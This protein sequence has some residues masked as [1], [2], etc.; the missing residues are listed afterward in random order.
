MKQFLFPAALLAFL[1]GGC[2]APAKTQRAKEGITFASNPIVAHR[3]AFKKNRLPE[4][5]IASLKHAIALNC[6]GSEFDVQMTADDSLVIN[7]DPHYNKLP[8]E[9]TPYAELIK[10]PLSNG[11]Q[12]PTLRTYLLE[13]MKNNRSTRLVLEIK[14][15]VISKER[16]QLIAQ[17]AVAL[18]HELGA[19]RMTVYISFDYDIC[20]KVKELDPKTHVQYLNGDKSPEVV[21]AGGLDGV[22]YHYSVFQKHPE[23]I[24]QAKQQH[25]A[26]N[27]WTVNTAAEMDWLLANGFEFITTNEPELLTERIKKT[28]AAKG[29]KLV[30]SDEFNNNG[31]PDDHKW[32]YDV[33]GSGWG[34]RELQYY[35]KADSNNALVKD[36]TLRIIAHKEKREQN[37]Y[38]SAR[39]ITKGKGDWLYG[40]VEVSAKLPAG[41]GVWP[42]IWM[43]PTDWKY[44]GWPASGEMDIMENVGYN[45]DTVFSS[46]HTK[47]FNHVIGTQKTKGFFLKDAGTAFHLY[48]VEWNKDQIDFFVDDRLFFSFKNTGK[49]FEEWPFDQ[50]FHLLLNMAMGGNWGGKMGVDEKLDRAVMEVDY[51]RVFQK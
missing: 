27:A 35:T 32:G 29:W 5:S 6:T 50:K 30:W 51:V 43:L 7:H 28:S 10:T 11:E 48:A 1:L 8:I 47:S 46:V 24:A 31:L 19:A 4:N 23:W 44:G 36:G 16:G 39:L 2:S 13:G 15:S 33:G 20:K 25:I 49:G 21:K 41:R 37:T 9:K 38:T 34:N 26:L 12:L 14:P 42:A 22:D 40:R 18:V 3:G 17:R 45:P